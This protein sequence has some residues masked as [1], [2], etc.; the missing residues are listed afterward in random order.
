MLGNEGFTSVLKREL[1]RVGESGRFVRLD[2][3]C[4]GVAAF[5][6]GELRLPCQLTRCVEADHWMAAQA[7]AGPLP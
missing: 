3:D 7:H 5:C 6:S 2:T 1:L 4:D